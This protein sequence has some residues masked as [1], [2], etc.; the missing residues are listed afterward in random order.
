MELNRVCPGPWG[1]QV[2]CV[3]FEFC[4][5]S[6]NTIFCQSECVTSKL[7]GGRLVPLAWRFIWNPRKQLFLLICKCSRIVG[8]GQPKRALTEK[9]ARDS[10]P[11]IYTSQPTHK[12]DQ[13]ANMSAPHVSSHVAGPAEPSASQLASRPDS[14]ASSAH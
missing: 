14:R 6:R 9:E 1:I 2:N 5:C 4:E 10:W 3:F 12:P 8:F 11:A 7:P 13:P